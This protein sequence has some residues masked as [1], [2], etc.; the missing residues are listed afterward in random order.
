ME[1]QPTSLIAAPTAAVPKAAKPLAEGRATLK[2]LAVDLACA[3]R[4]ADEWGMNEGICN[5][6]TI[7]VPQELHPHG[8]ADDAFLIIK[9]GTLWS[10]ATAK[11][12]LL[13][14]TKGKILC[15]WGTGCVQPVGYASSP[16]SWACASYDPT[17]FNIHKAVHLRL[18]SAGAV[19]LHTHMPSVTT[20]N[21]LKPEAG[22]RILQ[23]HQNSCRFYNNVAYDEN[24]GGLA[25]DTSEGCAEGDRIASVLEGP[26][27]HRIRAAFLRNHGILIVAENLWEAMDDLYYLERSALFQVE[28]LKAAGGDMSKLAIMADEVAIDTYK[29]WERFRAEGGWKHFIAHKRRLLR[30]DPAIHNLL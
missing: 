11:D 2:D 25:D 9:Y 14:N 16:A 7:A 5:H 27:Q 1:A 12:M 22:G 8:L 28:A 13:V 24:F 15:D 4:L 17:A 10:E 19:V 6:F 30:K 26:S 21:A 23:V 29:Q 20:L 3:Y 18:G